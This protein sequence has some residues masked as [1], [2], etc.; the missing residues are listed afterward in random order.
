MEKKA[1]NF[2][3]K[4]I[5]TV[6]GSIRL[7]QAEILNRSGFLQNGLKIINRYENE[8]ISKATPLG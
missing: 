2:V 7:N 5:K 8:I 6:E 1:S 3:S 4:V